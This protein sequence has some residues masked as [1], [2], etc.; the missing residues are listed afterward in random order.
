ME[1]I[2]NHYGINRKADQFKFYIVR[3]KSAN[4]NIRSRKGASKYGLF[5]SYEGKINGWISLDYVEK[6]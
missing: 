2:A 3:V 6:V 4:L 5:K 1:C